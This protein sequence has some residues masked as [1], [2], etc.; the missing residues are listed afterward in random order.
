[1]FWQSRNRVKIISKNIDYQ[2]IMCIKV[3]NFKE[4]SI[5]INMKIGTKS[6]LFGAHCF[7]IHPWFVA[8]SWWKLYGFPF[9]P[10]LWV[11]FFVHD[12][13]YIGKPNMDGDEGEMHPFYGAFVMGALF[14]RK[15]FEFSLYHSR[16]L[17]KKLGGQPSKL[18]IADK[19]AIAVT[20]AWLYL[21]MVNWTG[22]IHEYIKL[23]AKRETQVEGGVQNN[24]YESMQLM[25]NTQKEWY[26]NL[27]KYILSWVDEH[28][29]GKIDTWTPS[30]KK[31]VNE[32]GVWQ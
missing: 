21:P 3:R 30:Q 14:G 29:D 12:L 5:K 4:I 20:P 15:W 22:E 26:S 1:M 19:L 25:A 11:A 9:D 24:K 13:G 10:R 16:F 23:S 27:Q 17:A 32:S 31:A 2:L 18:C 8:Y 28:K 6:V 7:F